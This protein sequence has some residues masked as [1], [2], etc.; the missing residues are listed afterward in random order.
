[1][2]T[3]EKEVCG[4]V[5]EAGPDHSR[6]AAVGSWSRSQQRRLTTTKGAP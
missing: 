6:A 4:A 3:S 5:P 1:M 2:E